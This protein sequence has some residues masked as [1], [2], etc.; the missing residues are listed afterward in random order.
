M[1]TEDDTL[2]KKTKTSVH[3]ELYPKPCLA[4]GSLEMNNSSLCSPYEV[5]V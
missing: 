3:E 5:P 1:P 4:A 2:K